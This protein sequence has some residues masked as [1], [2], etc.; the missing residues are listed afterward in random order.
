[1]GAR[2]SVA[3]PSFPALLHS[4][5]PAVANPSYAAYTWSGVGVEIPIL[6]RILNLILD[7]ILGNPSF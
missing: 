2:E 3:D 1:M 4:K 5:S 6:R 7:L